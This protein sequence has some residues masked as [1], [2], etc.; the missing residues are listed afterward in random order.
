MRILNYASAIS[1][2]HHQLLESDPDVFVIGQGLWSPWYAGQS[3]SELDTKF[4][5]ERIIDTPVSENAVTGAA[6]G[7]AMS[8][9]KPILFHPRMD[10]MLLA[11][12][13]LVN[14]ASNW[15][16]LF[17]GQVNIPLT[18]RAAINR[19]G[20]QGAQHSQALQAF[21]SHTPGIKVLMPA[22]A[23]DAKGLLVAAVNDGNPVMY[24]DD[25]WCYDHKEDVPE[26]LYSEEIGK[27]KVLREG[28]QITIVGI[29]H[30]ALQALKAAEEL[31]KEGLSAEVI[32]LRSV[33]PWDVHTILRSV[34][35][36]GHV[37]IADSAW[38]NGSVAAEIASTITSKCWKSNLK[39]APVRVGLPNTPAPV[40]SNLEKVYY[41]NEN[42][43][44]YAA[45][46]CLSK[47][48]ENFHFIPSSDIPGMVV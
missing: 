28:N 1:E 30:M 24:I 44:V 47:I 39:S 20:E 2:A 43:V 17:D 5:K 25:R 48:S 3:I 46:T 21:F 4:G 10:F 7:A 41:P 37:V 6:I 29:G 45:K 8:G 22:T 27:A 38:V 42:T 9:L 40:S 36:T 14:Q 15:S 16:Y 32:D 12:D 26:E 34:E 23:R 31:A 13:P 11:T 33:K 19:G 18:I 35:K